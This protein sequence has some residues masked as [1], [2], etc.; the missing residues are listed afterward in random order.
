MSSPLVRLSERPGIVTPVASEPANRMSVAARHQPPEFTSATFRSLLTSPARRYSQ[1][2]PPDSTMAI[3]CDS[4]STT[5]AMEFLEFL[6]MIP[7]YALSGDDG[8]KVDDGAVQPSS[9]PKR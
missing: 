6:G 8:T 5:D 3:V 1:G 2:R 9:A 7:S 4:P